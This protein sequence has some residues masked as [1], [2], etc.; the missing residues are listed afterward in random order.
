[1][2]YS[3][4]FLTLG[5]YL[6]T[7]LP[8]LFLYFRKRGE[9][10][11]AVKFFWV[12]NFICLGLF[13]VGIAFSGSEITDNSIYVFNQP[14][15]KIITGTTFGL[16]LFFQINRALYAWYS[17]F[18]STGY[19]ALRAVM[20]SLLVIVLIFAFI[21]IYSSSFSAKKNS[22]DNEKYDIGVVLGAAV[23]SQN[24][25]SPTLLARLNKAK[26]L[27]DKGILKKIH[28]TGS[29][30]PGEISEAEAAFRY[31]VSLGMPLNDLLMEKKTNST[32]EQIRFIRN[33]LLK[34]KKFEKIA[35]ISDTYHL[36][37]IKQ[38]SSFYGIKV[39]LFGAVIKLTAQK[40]LYYRLRESVAL[41]YFWFFGL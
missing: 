8:I 16:L 25:P 38:I 29:N 12:N 18:R 17:N 23:L 35:I 9:Y 14:L 7:I 31:L 30:A 1:M 6:L 19:I 4:N 2:L 21:L 20:G 41:L 5:I 33:T 39:S 3:G 24:K 11:S 26:E 37:R 27:Y 22:Q 32:T 10:Q 28:L 15:L 34:N 40:A 13:A 36:S